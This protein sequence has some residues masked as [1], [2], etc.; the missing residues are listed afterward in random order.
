[1]ISLGNFGM[2]HAYLFGRKLNTEK[3]EAYFYWQRG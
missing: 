2:G 3:P 1:V